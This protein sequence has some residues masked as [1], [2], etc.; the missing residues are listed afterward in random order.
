[1]SKFILFIIILNL[2]VVI[3]NL[4]MW[5]KVGIENESLKKENEELRYYLNLEYKEYYKLT[6]ELNNIKKK[7]D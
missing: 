1:M 4:Y 2:I 7:K 3:Y 6:T 5:F